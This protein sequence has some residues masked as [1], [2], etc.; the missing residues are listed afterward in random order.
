MHLLVRCQRLLVLNEL[1]N[2]CGFE[3]VKTSG[4]IAALFSAPSAF[5]EEL[6]G[7][8]FSGVLLF[9][10]LAFSSDAVVDL[11]YQGGEQ[12]CQPNFHGVS[13]FLLFQS[14]HLISNL[15]HC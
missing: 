8:T 3:S 5:A 14:Y 13:I 7:L 1:L 9:S 11:R 4:L 2:F 6:L 10:L 15:L 12:F